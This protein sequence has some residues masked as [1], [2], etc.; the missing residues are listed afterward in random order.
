MLKEGD[1][2]LN[3]SFIG[4][5][6]EGRFKER[7]NR[8]VGRV[9]VDK[10]EY[11]CHIADTG[12]L[13]EILTEGRPVLLA[14][15]PPGLKTD[16]KLVACKMEH[17]ALIN[18]SVHSKI[19]EQAIRK[20]VLGFVPRTIKREIKVGKSRLDFLID[21]I[22]AELKGSNLLM[23]KSCVFPDA[24]TVRGLKHLNELIELKE[25]GK[26]AAL[27]I[28]ALRDCEYFLPNL[29]LDPAFSE[30]FTQAIKKG[31]LFFGFKVKID[32]YYAVY[33]GEL[34]LGDFFKA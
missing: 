30:A 28:M 32:G 33:N 26:K 31:V 19:A 9:E 22:Y 18:T 27:I 24:P 23:G 34:K 5:L 15:N 25:S 11:S 12:R 8:F 6:V 17:W 7:L 14:K 4:K 29:K 13:K 10:K 1:R 2:L 21:D 3:L 16:F 20:G